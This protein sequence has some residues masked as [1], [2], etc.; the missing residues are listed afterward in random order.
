MGDWELENISPIREGKKHDEVERTASVAA[1]LAPSFDTHRQS[2]CPTASPGSDG[3]ER[4]YL[5]PAQAG[6]L[7][8]PIIRRRGANQKLRNR[9]SQPGR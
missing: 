2:T 7:A 3:Q 6:S 9:S 5:E 1:T 4:A 8:T